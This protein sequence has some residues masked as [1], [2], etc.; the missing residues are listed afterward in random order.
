MNTLAAGIGKAFVALC[1][2]IM[3]SSTEAVCTA[4]AAIHE[5]LG[6]DAD[7]LV[8]LVPELQGLL[9]DPTIRR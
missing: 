3:E 4:Q 1:H 2:K 6:N 5:Q 9:S 8:Y 7:L